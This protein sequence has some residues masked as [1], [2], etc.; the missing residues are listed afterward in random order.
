MFKT[1]TELLTRK[2]VYP[3]D[4]INSINKFNET[5]LPPINEFYS[6]LNNTNILEDDYNY[7]QTV[8]NTFN[9]KTIRNYH[10]LSLKTDVLLLANFF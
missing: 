1:N 4:Y 6:K 7:A 5:K 2:G 9:C 10:N 8:F 3:Y